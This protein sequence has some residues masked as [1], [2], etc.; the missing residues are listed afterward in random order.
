MRAPHL[1]VHPLS[2]SQREIW[3][4]QM[5]HEGVALYNIGG[6]VDLPGEIDVEMF[7]TA[8]QMLIRRHD[9]LRLVLMDTADED[10]MP[11]QKVVEPWA[12]EV[13]L[14][15]FSG[16]ADPRGAA[17]AWMQA[18]FEEPFTLIGQPLWRYDLVKM[19][20]SEYGWLLQYH[21]LIVDGWGVA[22]IN[23]SLAEIYSSLAEQAWS[24]IAP[25]PSYTAFI[26]SDR[27][28]V[29]SP[30]FERDRAYWL[31]QYA[32][33]A[34]E[35]LLQA[36]HHATAPKSEGTAGSAV[37]S[38]HLP[39]AMYRELEALAAEQGASVFHVLLGALYVY[40]TRTGQREDFAVG[41]PVLNRSNAQMRATAGLF[42]GV[43]PAH[44]QF[45]REITFVELI[46]GI[47]K[48]LKGHYRHQRF[49]VSEINRAVGLQAARSA[50]FDVTL[51]FENSGNDMDFAGIRGQLIPVLNGHA[52]DPLTVFVRDFHDAHDV[53]VDFV[54]NLAYLDEAEVR[55]LQ[56]RFHVLLAAALESRG[57]TSVQALPVMTGHDEE[58]LR[59]WNQTDADYPQDLTVVDLFE[60]QVD[61]SPDATAVVFE[62]QRLSYAQLD[63]R[64]NQVAHALIEQGVGPDT[65]V[66]LCVPRSLEMVVGLLGILKAGGA[67][68]PLDP[69]Y[70]QDRL[71]FMVT[72]AQAQ[73]VLSH[74]AVLDRLPLS[75]A[76][77]LRLDD[78]N[79]WA[80]QPGSRPARQAS[81]HDLAYVI[82]TSGST[83]VPKGAMNEHRGVVNRLQ[84]MQDEYRLDAADVVLQKTPFSFDVSVWEFFW[85]LMTGARLVLARPGGHQE[86][87]Y[88]AELI[89]HERITTLHFV[90]PMLGA[91]LELATLPAGHALRR[92]VCSGEALPVD[93]ERRCLER[94]PEVGLH[95]LYGPTEAA[96]DVTYWP[97]EPGSLGE[98]V[99][100]G[101]PVSNTRVHLLDTDQQPVPPGV[102]GELCIAG[103]Q[104]GRGYLNRP[105]LTAEK[106][107]VAEVLGRAERLYRTGDLARWL[108]DGNLE[109][110]GRLD[111]QVKLRGFRIELGEVESALSA[112]EAVS[113]AAVVLREREGVKALAGYVVLRSAVEVSELK[114]WL[115]A[116][117]PEYMVPSSLTVLES[118]PLTPN[119]KVDRRALPEP[120]LAVS[121]GRALSGPTEELLGGIWAEVLGLAS[122]SA[123][124]NF[125]ELGGHSLLATRVASRIRTQLGVDCPLR[126][127]L[128]QPVLVDLAAW[129]DTQQRGSAVETIAVL[130]EGEPLVLSPA[131]ERLWFLAQ[132][133]GASSTYNMPAALRLSGELDEAALRASLVALT[134][135]QASL[136]Q[137]FPVDAAG[138][139]RLAE[140]APWDPLELADLQH[141]D[142][143]AQAAEVERLARA[144][145]QAPFDLATGPLFKVGLLRLSPLEHVLLLNLHHSIADGWSIAVLVREWA[146]L[147]RAARAGEAP[148]LRPLP[149]LPVAYRDV[150]AW[151]QRWSTSEAASAQLAWWVAQLQGAP[152][153]LELPTDFP[154]P[155]QQSYRGASFSRTLDAA[156]S[157]AVERLARAQG[158]TV[159]MTLLAALQLVLH[160]HSAQ[161]DISVGTPVANREHA[162]TEHLVGLFVN[163]LVLRSH[164]DPQQPFAEL[165]AQVR[166]T[167]LGAFARQALP[168]ERVV[169]ALS[170]ERSLAHAPLFQVMFVLQNNDAADFDLDGLQITPVEQSSSVAKVDLTLSA[171]QTPQGI[172][173]HWEFASDLFT[174]ARI[175]RLA[176]HFEQALQVVTA[177]PDTPLQ[178]ID[179]LTQDDKAQLLAWNRTEAD[180]PQDLTVVDLFERQVDQTPDAT[181]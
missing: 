109:Y 68:V 163:T 8:V 172:L 53:Q 173:C 110:L 31:A 148:A 57:Q 21:H 5:L 75:E 151:Q 7:R 73:V 76:Q 98:S 159:F 18:R 46:R 178:A 3:F 27:E 91:F 94:L 171:Q 62:G 150:A 170:P 64:A 43:T 142:P 126:V 14:H 153:L 177:Q 55:A 74:S 140:R 138:Q 30:A 93:L 117:L 108:P 65:L 162:Q 181:A 141:L 29:E 96:V 2:S 161:S 152:A 51:S 120:E 112:H 58:R 70:P 123:E 20:P 72:D 115:K 78:S 63:R 15:D 122:L 44:F 135:R 103:V 139:V 132:L 10:G 52:Q 87:Q 61:T 32:N 88:L 165:L 48:A 118:L 26:A 116:R 136:R 37:Q 28:Y 97:C 130:A 41:L 6:W 147:Y 85:P 92:I 101:R 143:E 71:T 105:E 54:H 114:G 16:E 167:A 77:V 144:H 95:N 1:T 19:G 67:Y 84:W 146:A 166:H 81:P 131:Q 133:E 11:L 45:G 60:A 179:I 168:F 66:G 99:P 80:S 102:P 56:E 59:A 86:P 34:P 155:A 4:D 157:Q 119:G 137:S 79:V 169:E 106:F 175:E 22:L 125:F 82:Y 38:M 47:G 176:R 40:F 174:Q 156:L 33:G 158:A 104:V 24:E 9:A 180:Y 50:L 129:L 17:H 12:A 121:V 83:G 23:R 113:A 107:I 127:L 134:C 164:L 25:S 89:T 128:E 90:P 111:H 42:V 145:A 36:R 160:R 124:S 13:P 69:D 100:I 35:P 149:A 154:R 49:P 39:R